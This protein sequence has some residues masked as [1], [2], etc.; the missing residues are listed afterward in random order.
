M[1]DSLPVKVSPKA[2]FEVVPQAAQEAYLFREFYLEKFPIGWHF[3]PEI[4]LTLIL[5]SS[6]RRWVGDHVTNYAPGDLVLIGPNVPHYWMNDVVAGSMAHS[7]VIQFRDDRFG[8]EFFRLTELEPVVALLKRSRRGIRFTG[9]GRDRA[10]QAMQLLLHGGGG[11]QRVLD[12]FSI[13][14]GLAE[15]EAEDYELLSS[16]DFMPKLDGESVSRVDKIYEY[17]ARRS[18]SDF[19]HT[20]LAN[21]LGTSPS[22]LSHYFKRTVGC[23][24]SAFVAEVRVGQACRQLIL[25][26]KPVSEIAFASGFETLSNFNAWFRR[27][28]GA[29]PR[30]FRDSHRRGE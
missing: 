13:L 26:D 29:S 8:D 10:A 24:L 14:G 12:L 17:I 4:E 16:P 7:L 1:L 22:G 3:H 18:A 6:G 19:N 5:E 9:A 25:T 28:R 2:R 21:L 30:E 27:L 20:E 15:V 11:L 23:T